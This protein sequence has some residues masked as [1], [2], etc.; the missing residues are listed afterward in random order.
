MTIEKDLYRII[1]GRLQ[2]ARDGL[3][4]YI[5][6][7]DPELKI[8]SYS[9][10][11][12]IY[13][14]SMKSE[15]PTSSEMMELLVN[16]DLWTP[17]D[18]RKAEEKRKK[19]EDL[20]VSAFERYFKNKELR[21]IKLRIN[22]LEQERASLLSKRNQYHRETC[23]GLAEEERRTWLI[24]NSVTDKDGNKIELDASQESE[25]ID[26]Y[27]EN[28]IT[29]EKIRAIAR[30][31]PW[32]SMWL[33]GNKVGDLFGKPSTQFSDY[34]LSLCSNSNMYDGV[35]QSPECPP[36]EVINDDDCLDGWFIKQSRER[37]EDRK[38]SNSKNVL[39]NQKIAN[40]QEVFIM[41]K[42]RE[43]A[44]KIYDM[45]NDMSK[46]IIGQRSSKIEEKGRVKQGEFEDVARSTELEANQMMLQ[47]LRGRK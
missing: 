39:K 13:E 18:D 41:A 7:P 40:S 37:E 29:L 25:V 46:Q 45:N 19:I 4:L 34:Q 3:F 32:R 31:E 6:D 2:F 14:D 5:N 22:A 12:R 33:A 27:I 43:E 36:Q 1:T 44:D 8:N 16:K 42:D 9:V 26:C 30:N 21:N 38:K 10:Y 15:I 11:D 20:K 35:Y 47:K 24:L 28:I 23:E 17:M